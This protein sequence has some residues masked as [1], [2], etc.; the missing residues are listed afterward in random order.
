MTAVVHY[1]RS[2]EQEATRKCPNQPC[3]TIQE[4]AERAS[5]FFTSES[6]FV[7]MPGHHSLGTLITIE[8]VSDITILG[9]NGSSLSCMDISCF[10]CANITNLRI[11]GVIFLLGLG[12]NESSSAVLVHESE[13]VTIL[14]S[15]FRGA[16]EVIGSAFMFSPMLITDTQI[17]ISQCVFEINSATFGGALFVSRSSATLNGNLFIGNKAHIDGGAVYCQTSIINLVETVGNVFLEN[18]AEQ[19][20]GALYCRNCTVNISTDDTLELK[21]AQFLPQKPMCTDFSGNFAGSFGGAVYLN[22]SFLSLSGTNITFENN[23]AS[24]GGAVYIIKSTVTSSTRHLMFCGNTASQ[25]GG[26][27]DIGISSVMLGGN[28]TTQYFLDNHSHGGS[29]GAI[30]CFYGNVEIRGR[31][32]FTGNSAFIYGGALWVIAGHF[33]LSGS[34]LFSKNQA[35]NG[36]ALNAGFEAH[37]LLNGSAVDFV[38]NSA[39]VMDGG[40]ISLT[41][42]Q[43]V[44]GADEVNFLDNSAVDTGGG[45]STNNGSSLVSVSKQLM[46]ERNSAGKLGGGI[47]SRRSVDFR[48][49][50]AVFLNNTAYSTGAAL[51]TEREKVWLGNVTFISNS[52]T[53][54]FALSSQITFNGDAT[55]SGNSGIIGGGMGLQSSTVYFMSSA[56]C[57]SNK[58]VRGGA[59]NAYESEIFFNGAAPLFSLNT[60]LR[61][62][63]GLYSVTSD[64]TINRHTIVVF[65]NNTA[66]NGGAIYFDGS[67][68]LRLEPFSTLT[69]SNNRASG[70]GGAIYHEDT[71]TL[72]QCEF[73]LNQGRDGW[74]QVHDGR[75]QYLPR[76]FVELKESA[77]T[78]NSFSIISHHDS[79]GKDGS[80]LYGGL[81]DRCRMSVG[82]ILLQELI[83]VGTVPRVLLE[84]NVLQINGT[85]NTTEK[86]T[87]EPYLLC[88]CGNGQKI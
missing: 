41:Y 22:S 27:I 39:T 68:I 40:A 88:F 48:L 12:S 53:S 10:Q 31:S 45:I 57:T 56:D 82:F 80:F 59:I 6:E 83:E 25:I 73:E 71:V 81:L 19:N 64:I 13:N 8:N 37:V 15:T 2:S 18:S 32:I 38:G 63:G 65:T 16:G 50:S 86:V 11:Q 52:N 24:L 3:L 54:L 62:G 46:F 61:Y 72:Y 9:N 1:I 85:D 84:R 67:S 66:E 20:G 26:A 4:Y 44:M 14:N 75:I 79:A 70:Y 34:V 58:G 35:Q 69:T 49:M 7:L 28:D 55:F 74:I 76:C 43:L 78:S 87:S 42:S 30:G 29:A 23:F 33:S 51:R 47:L 17:T 77:N 5:M 60:A 36:G 21:D